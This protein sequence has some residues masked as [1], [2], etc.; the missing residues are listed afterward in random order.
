MK[1]DETIERTYETPQPI[2]LYVEMGKGDLRVTATAT[3]TT[4]LRITGRD[5]DQVHLE[6][7]RDRV[8]VV[9]PR[10]R[11]GFLGGGDSALVVEVTLPEDSRLALRTGSA[12]VRVEGPVETSQVRT[13]SGDVRL[14]R[15]DGPATVE[16][17]SG[18]VVVDEAAAELRVKSGSGDVRIGH[19][20]SAVAV[21]TGSG[22]VVVGSND[23]PVAVKTGSGDLTVTEAR[24]DVSLATGS[25]DL[26][27]GTAVRGLVS[28]KGA[29]SD[30][31]VGIRSGTPVWTDVS[32]VTGSIRS[33]LPGAGEPTPGQD[34]VELRARTVSGDVVLTPA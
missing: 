10:Q 15:I 21:S 28:A 31:R 27:I 18:D 8:T 29:S 30:I 33:G 23:G 19:A 6:H 9:G 26:H 4:T 14:E 5:V 11:T 12:D 20:T 16:T 1:N 32:T 13:G 34:H 2:D 3:G 22:D 7:T 25:G 17:G 24:T